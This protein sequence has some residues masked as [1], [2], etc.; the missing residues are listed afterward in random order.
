MAESVEFGRWYEQKGVHYFFDK[1]GNGTNAV[2]RGS[3]N[4]LAS[5]VHQ[6]DLTYRKD[7]SYTQSQIEEILRGVLVTGKTQPREVICF[8]NVG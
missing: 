4:D 6:L 3:L 8:S 1:F 2:V 7:G 5:F